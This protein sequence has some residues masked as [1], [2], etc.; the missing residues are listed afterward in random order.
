MDPNDSTGA[1]APEVSAETR[2][3]GRQM[4]RDLQQQALTQYYQELDAENVG[5]PPLQPPLPVEKSFR[6]PTTIRNDP[7]A[8]QKFYR[9]CEA[10]QLEAVEQCMQT[11]RPDPEYVQY[12]TVSAAKEGRADIVK[13]LLGAGAQLT[14]IIVV[15]MC[16][17]NPS[18]DFFE[19]LVQKH[20][21]HPNQVSHPS[22]IPLLHLLKD[23]NE[24]IIRY[25]LE[26][27]ADPNLGP[28]GMHITGPGAPIN[29]KCGA[30]LEKAAVWCSTSMIDLLLSHG[31]KLEYA[32]PIHRAAWS[33]S[34]RHNMDRAAMIS[35][36]VE[37]GVDING[38]DT[39]QRRINYQRGTPLSFC[40]RDDRRDGAELLL[41]LGACPDRTKE[42]QWYVD[43]WV[44]VMQEKG[45]DQFWK[46]VRATAM[47][48]LPYWSSTGTGNTWVD[49]M[50]PSETKTQRGEEVK[51]E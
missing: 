33:H 2:R 12:G 30:A 20:G 48:A 43:M 21:W 27:G 46:D 7:P 50:I 31:A 22:N 10:G 24:A 29:R 3:R 40:Y 6:S 49:S 18:L 4:M 44:R 26:Q 28:F 25:L 32:I 5:R 14:D 15:E 34:I 35:H 36:L 1:Q 39:N 9:D 8:L 23:E 42:P 19:Y 13:Y 17:S 16:D 38:L 45:E 37:L 41:R 11:L 47:K 51:Q